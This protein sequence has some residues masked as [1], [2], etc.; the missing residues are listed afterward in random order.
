[1]KNLVNSLAKATGLTAEELT[2]AFESLQ[3]DIAEQLGDELMAIIGY[4]EDRTNLE[5]QI[6]EYIK[7]NYNVEARGVIH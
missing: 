5:S 6:T 1:M 3:V 4:D 2:I 7:D